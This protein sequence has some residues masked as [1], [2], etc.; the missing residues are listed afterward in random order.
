L[1]NELDFRQ[2]GWRYEI[3]SEGKRELKG[4]VLN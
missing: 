3:N 4:I 2:E 1:L